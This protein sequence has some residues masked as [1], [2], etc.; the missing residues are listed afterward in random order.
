MLSRFALYIQESADQ[1]MVEGAKDVD[2]LQEVQSMVRSI[3]VGLKTVVWCITNYR[4][5]TQK[6]KSRD[7]ASQASLVLSN[8][9]SLRFAARYALK[10]HVFEGMTLKERE[11][12]LFSLM[13]SIKRV[14]FTRSLRLLPLPEQVTVIEALST[15]PTF[16]WTPACYR[17]K[18]AGFPL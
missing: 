10:P 12:K 16:S 8:Y 9:C 6:D 15:L 4:L 18:L 14:L 5:S 11:S 7:Q 17:P 1:W 3:I 2:S 13:S